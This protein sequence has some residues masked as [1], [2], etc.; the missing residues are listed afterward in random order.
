VRPHVFAAVMA[1]GIVSVAMLDHGHRLVSAVLAVI[2]VALL[3]VLM[4]ASLRAWRSQGW[5]LRELDVSIGLFSYVAACCVVVAR[6]APHRVASIILVP[7]A[8]QGW[9]SLMP[10]TLRNAWRERRTIATRVHGG[11]ELV[12]VATSGLAMACVAVGAVFWAIP[13]WVAALVLYVVITGLLVRR[14]ARE[15]SGRDLSSPDTWIVMGALA[16]A[17]LTGEHLRHA[18][19]AGPFTDGLLRVTIGTWLLATLWIPVLLA[20]GLRRVNAWPAVFPIGM[21]SSATFAVYQETGWAVLDV[22]SLVVC[23]LAAALWL[24]TA[25]PAAGRLVGALPPNS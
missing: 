4:V 24:W 16:I 22:V 18:L 10:T 8:V 12:S 20:L 15:G 9:L 11:W 19:P 2:A 7:M 3:P 23:W 17:T 1:T 21:Y 13:L 6:L 5:S 14:W 25:V